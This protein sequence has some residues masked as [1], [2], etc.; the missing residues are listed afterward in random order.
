MDDT[1]A[2]K[3]RPAEPPAHDLLCR[4]SVTANRRVLRRWQCVLDPLRR[5]VL[6]SDGSCSGSTLSRRVRQERRSIR[7]GLRDR[8]RG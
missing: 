8:Q 1:H 2:A 3:K 6:G 4:Q 5:Q 7:G